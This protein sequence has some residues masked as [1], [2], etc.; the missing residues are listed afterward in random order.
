MTGR[1]V[2][3]LSA[4]DM[5]TVSLVWCLLRP[6][7]LLLWVEVSALLVLVLAAFVGVVFAAQASQPRCGKGRT[8]LLARLGTYLIV[9]PLL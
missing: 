5:L 6:R 9:G 7:L 3:A 2:M 8:W 4:G 1:M